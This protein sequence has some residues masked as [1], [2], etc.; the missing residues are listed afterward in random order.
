M[1]PTM[2]FNTVNRI[3]VYEPTIDLS[4]VPADTN[5]EIACAVPGVK[6]GDIFVSAGATAE[7]DLTVGIVGGWVSADDEVTLLVS[8]PTASP[9]DESSCTIRF[10]VARGNA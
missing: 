7:D 8:N 3:Y 4:S 5:T 10:L 1:A 6:A 2:S 9:I